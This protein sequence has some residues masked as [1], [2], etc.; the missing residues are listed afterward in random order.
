MQGTQQY[1]SLVGTYER[2]KPQHKILRRKYRKVSPCLTVHAHIL[3]VKGFL[4]VYLPVIVIIKE[5]RI[6]RKIVKNRAFIPQQRIKQLL[7]FRF[8][9]GTQLRKNTLN[10]CAVFR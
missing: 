3:A 2:T 7:T 8:A 6:V 4:R 1:R 5:R 10:T 9:A